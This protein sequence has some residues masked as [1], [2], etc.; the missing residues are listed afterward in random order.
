MP[1]PFFLIA[2]PCQGHGLP[3]QCCLGLFTSCSQRHP[4]LLCTIWSSASKELMQRSPDPGCQ[5]LTGTSW[6]LQSSP[7]RW[8]VSGPQNAFMSCPSPTFQPAGCLHL[9]CSHRTAV[10]E[11]HHY[12]GLEPAPTFHPKCMH[13]SNSMPILHQGIVRISTLK[14]AT[15]SDLAVME[16]RI[17][18]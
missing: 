14:G 15:C 16:A 3:T 17:S 13:G 11:R 6:V 9:L 4:G 2:V 18:S 5:G 12:H 10:P 7:L 1:Y 8:K